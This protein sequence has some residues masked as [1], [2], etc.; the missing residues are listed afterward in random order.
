MDGYIWT[1]ID[2]PEGESWHA[3]ECDEQINLRPEQAKWLNC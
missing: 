2:P 1:D 3:L